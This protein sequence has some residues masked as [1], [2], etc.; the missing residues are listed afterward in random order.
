MPLA[1]DIRC[2]DCLHFVESTQACQEYKASVDPLDLRNCFFFS[3]IPIIVPTTEVEEPVRIQ[4][5]LKAVKKKSKHKR[6]SAQAS[7]ALA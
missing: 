7:V 2:D 5:P 6:K 4:A 1:K 3:K